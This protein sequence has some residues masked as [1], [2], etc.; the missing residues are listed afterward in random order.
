M[1]RKPNVQ[2]VFGVLVQKLYRQAQDVSTGVCRL[3]YVELNRYAVAG[4]RRATTA[5]VFLGSLRKRVVR[6]SLRAGECSPALKEKPHDT[7]TPTN[8]RR[9]DR[10]RSG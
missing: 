4:A 1:P 5:L 6:W 8:A 9:H 7:V 3:H 2:A 10:A